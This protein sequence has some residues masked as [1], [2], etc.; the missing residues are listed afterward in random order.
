M[1]VWSKNSYIA[2]ELLKNEALLSL[3]TQALKRDLR[4]KYSCSEADA[5]D[6]IN[7]ARRQLELRST[8]RTSRALRPEID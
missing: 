5:S 8:E 3:N 1:K 7:L 2:L 6:A 4:D